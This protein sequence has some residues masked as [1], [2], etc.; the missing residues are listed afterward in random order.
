MAGVAGAVT[1][2]LAG[3]G[4]E[5]A[6]SCEAGPWKLR[7]DVFK[8][9]LLTGWP[10]SGVRTGAGVGRR[11]LGQGSSE[12]HVGEPGLRTV[13][14]GS[15]GCFRQ[16]LEPSPRSPGGGLGLGW[17]ALGWT[18]NRQDLSRPPVQGARCVAVELRPAGPGH[19]LVGSLYG[20][21][22]LGPTLALLLTLGVPLDPCCPL[23]MATCL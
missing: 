7:T 21:R 14:G 10:Q 19:G 13:V 17:G 12:G 5:F 3:Y 6:L 18:E 4:W 1:G 9:Q 23:S 15:L 2:G 11:G 8:G 20:M 22:S 16:R